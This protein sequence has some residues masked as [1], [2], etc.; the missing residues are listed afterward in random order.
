MCIPH[1]RLRFGTRET[2]SETVYQQVTLFIKLSTLKTD[3]ASCA[4]FFKKASLLSALSRE[5]QIKTPISKTS[6]E[7]SICVLICKHILASRLGTTLFASSHVSSCL[8]YWL[9]YALATTGICLREFLWSNVQL[10]LALLH[11]VLASL[12]PPAG[13]VLHTCTVCV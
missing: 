11:L 12:L 1:Q 4:A 8:P 9:Q 5:S 2:C 6:S 7:I 3:S 10:A 13:L